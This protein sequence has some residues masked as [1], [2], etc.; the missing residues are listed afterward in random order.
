MV[1]YFETKEA[2]AQFANDLQHNFPESYPLTTTTLQGKYAVCYAL[3]ATDLSSDG[4][5]QV[6]VESSFFN[7]P[8]NT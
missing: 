4:T 7:T 6:Q 2:A 3:S 5:E 1:N 8:V